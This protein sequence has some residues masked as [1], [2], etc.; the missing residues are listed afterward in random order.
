MSF[1]DRLVTWALRFV[2]RALER[3]PLKVIPN[4]SDPYVFRY[5]LLSLE[6]FGRVWI[7][8]FC[9]ADAEADITTIPGLG[10]CR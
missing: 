7:H 4:L 8:R 3:L 2:S 5:R 9:R 1:R 10:A 6:P